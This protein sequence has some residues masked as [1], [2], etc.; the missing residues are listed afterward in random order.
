VAQ[1][2]EFYL[3]KDGITI[4]KLKLGPYLIALNIIFVLMIIILL[5]EIISKELIV[6][7]LI[8]TLLGGISAII[9][10]VMCMQHLNNENL[11]RKTLFSINR[12]FIAKILIWCGI[13]TIIISIILLITLT[14]V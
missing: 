14:I 4:Y 7:V 2:E 6:R 11:W 12:G 8:V 10:G 5:A 3:K 9:L 1:L 13:G